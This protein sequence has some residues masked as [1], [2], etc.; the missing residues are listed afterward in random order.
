MAPIH[1]VMQVLDRMISDQKAALFEFRLKPDIAEVLTFMGKLLASHPCMRS[2]IWVA[3]LLDIRDIE[4]GRKHY[5][6]NARQLITAL[7]TTWNYVLCSLSFER[8][9]PQLLYSKVEVF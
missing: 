7:G 4:E 6:S 1:D 5:E 8:A 2:E 3:C 9:D